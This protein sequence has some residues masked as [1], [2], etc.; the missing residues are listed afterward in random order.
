M[1]FST[2]TQGKCFVS[3]TN[4]GER[5]ESLIFD[6]NGDRE[7]S[8]AHEGN[9]QQPLQS[10]VCFRRRRCCVP[11]GVIRESCTRS[12]LLNTGGVTADK[13]CSP[14]DHGTH[15]PGNESR[16]CQ[17][18]T[19]DLPSRE[20]E[21]ARFSSVTRGERFQPGWAV[22]VHPLLIRRCILGLPVISA[23][24]PKFS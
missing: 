3:K 17:Q 11:G 23:A 14:L 7:R 10:V 16:I 4:C 22:S 2:E 8:W 15:C 18:K 6:T 5:D 1:R 21:G 13:H 19:R 24:F 20:G 9:Y 12:S